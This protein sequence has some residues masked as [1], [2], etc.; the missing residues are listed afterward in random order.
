MPLDPDWID[1]PAC[2]VDK[3]DDLGHLGGWLRGDLRAPP[4]ILDGPRP[5]AIPNPRALLTGGLHHATRAG[6]VAWPVPCLE[7]DEPMDALLGKF[8]GSLAPYLPVRDRR[9]LRGVVHARTV[10]EHA[11]P[12]APR[13]DAAGACEPV[14]IL[15]REDPLDDARQGFLECHVDDLPVLDGNGRLEGRI[16]RAAV[17]FAREH[18][19]VGEGR[20]Q[21]VGERKPIFEDP[22]GG[23]MEG[24]AQEVPSAAPFD[25]LVELL[26]EHRTLFVRS[27]GGALLGALSAPLLLRAAIELDARFAPPRGRHPAKP[28][29]VPTQR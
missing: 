23:Q 11:F 10:L 4:V 29:A 19:D 20:Q 9:G 5:Y 27:G 17:L 3:E 8:H 6:K 18:R 1:A 7:P 14:I 2:A 25:E 24:G 13:L 15:R 28:A 16:G 22:V 26:A 21:Y 12:D